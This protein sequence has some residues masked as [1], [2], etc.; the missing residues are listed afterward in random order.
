[1]DGAGG[2]GGAAGQ[3]GDAGNPRDR[4]TETRTGTGLRSGALGL[5]N[6]IVQGITHIGPAIGM[7]LFIP[8]VASYAGRATPFAYLAA[9]VMM[10]LVAIVLS[11]LARHLPSA[12]GYYTY[13]SRT[14]HP[15]AG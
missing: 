12:G 2:I 7:V 15:R 6:V 4:A 11:Q 13:L 14:V 5:L 10:L 3:A 9:T 1:M 8:V